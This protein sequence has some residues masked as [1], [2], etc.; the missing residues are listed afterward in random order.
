[1]RLPLNIALAALIVTVLGLPGAAH[2]V[3]P[4]G[5]GKIAFVRDGQIWTINPDG[6]GETQL[7]SDA[8]PSSY[9]E[10]SPDG[11]RIAYTRGLLGGRTIRVMNADG[12]GDHHVYG[13][14]AAFSPTWSP[15][16]R[17]LAFAVPEAVG[18]C[19]FV[20]STW[21][22]DADGS[23]PT[24]IAFYPSESAR[25][26]DYEWSPR[27]DEIGYTIDHTDVGETD[28]ALL[29]LKPPGGN[30]FLTIDPDEV[31]AAPAWSPDGGGLAFLS[32]LGVVDY[33]VWTMNRDG[34][35]REQ[36]TNT[37]AE[38]FGVEWSPDDSKLVLSSGEVGCSGTCDAGL[39]LVNPDGSGISTLINTASSETSP[40]WQ[41]VVGPPPA[42]YPRPRGATPMT[43]S[44]VPASVP[45]AT[46]N[47]IHGTPLAFGSCAPPMQASPRLTVGTPDANG[48][49]VRMT[50]SVRI[51]AILG[52]SATESNEADLKITFSASDIR[53]YG[54]DTRSVCTSSNTQA[55]RDYAGGVRMR[56]NLRLT[57]RYN[58]PA[59]GGNQPGTMVDAPIEVDVHGCSPTTSD[60]SVG[61]T[62]SLTTTIGARLGVTE[63]RRAVMELGQVEVLDGGPSG[64]VG[65]GQPSSGMS[66]F[67]RQGVFIP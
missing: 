55:G 25:L 31:T 29:D 67:L 26:S 36:I 33:E 13:P 45:C 65:P 17:R 24:R 30:Q 32:D 51:H 23:N 43:V 1:M 39:Y 59:P 46:P 63:D 54:G 9:P 57:D 35:N 52:N 7:T 16:G 64:D 44:L 15:D 20:Q 47:R 2:A 8:S 21:R 11:K 40:D 18:C 27:G 42:G 49:P 56:A 60:A 48:A 62:C 5:N 19:L 14:P 4:G 66:T 50:A 10:W 53:C 58:L 22:V 37:G 41:P 28:A 6:T 34:T 12:T 3:Y 38:R 61:S